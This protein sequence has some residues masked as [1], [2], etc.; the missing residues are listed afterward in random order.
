MKSLITKFLVI[1]FVIST[2]NIFG[3][4]I[5]VTKKSGQIDSA[6]T[7]KLRILSKQRN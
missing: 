4:E 7:Q 1:F 6:F 5:I 2:S 3:N